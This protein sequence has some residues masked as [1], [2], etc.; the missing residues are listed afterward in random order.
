MSSTDFGA[1]K[2]DCQS[3]IDNGSVATYE[4]GTAV[5]C[6]AKAIWNVDVTAAQKIT[7]SVTIYA[8]VL[9]V[10]D[11]DA[12]VRSMPRLTRCSTS[13]PHGPDRT[14]SA[15]TSVSARSST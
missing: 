2:G 14:S 13:N 5:A 11:I 1:T 3:G 12:A 4:D 8:N 15:V 10:F 7:D 6:R 9:N